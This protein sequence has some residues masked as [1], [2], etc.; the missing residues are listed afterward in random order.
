MLSR[1]QKNGIKNGKLISTKRLSP[2]LFLE[3]EWQHYSL[4]SNG[5]ALSLESY[6]QLL[7]STLDMR[8]RLSVIPLVFEQ[9]QFET[10]WLAASVATRREH[11]LVGFS[12][13]CSG[14]RNLNDSRTLTGDILTLDH[15]SRDGKIVIDLWKSII[16]PKGDPAATAPHGFPGKSWEAFLKTEERYLSDRLRESLLSELKVLRTKLICR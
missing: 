13:A 11:A 3:F 15:F 7:S 4:K 1:S 14:A 9:T 2:A 5:L 10:K 6:R 16:V 12:E 8:Q